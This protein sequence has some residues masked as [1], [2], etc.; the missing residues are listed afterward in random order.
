MGRVGQVFNVSIPDTHLWSPLDPF[1]Y[2]VTVSL[3]STSQPAIF[4]QT[5]VNYAA[6]SAVSFC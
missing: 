6:N 3:T 1:L 5:V 4:S 2:N